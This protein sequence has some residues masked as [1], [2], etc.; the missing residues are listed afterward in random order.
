MI[1]AS[2]RI[3][4]TD[5]ARGGARSRPG[6]RSVPDRAQ[7]GIP[8]RGK[9]RGAASPKA[10]PIPSLLDAF[11]SMLPSRQLPGTSKGSRFACGSGS[12][13]GSGFA[14]ESWVTCGSGRMGCG[15]LFG[16]DQ[17]GS[18]QVGSDRPHSRHTRVGLSL[19]HG[20][21]PRKW[22]TS[23][24]KRALNVQRGFMEPHLECIT[25]LG[26]RRVL[27]FGIRGSFSSSLRGR[28]S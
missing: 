27:C 23:E 10:L 14:C 13:C 26:P 21:A 11:F 16:S 4:Q 9:S 15:V 3:P 8:L 25:C 2:P 7:S 17:V 6:S 20:V 5:P 19:C 12:A 18:H 28:N 22:P 1:P 24:C